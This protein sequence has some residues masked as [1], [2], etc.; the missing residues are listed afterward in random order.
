M[1]FLD[2]GGI[3]LERRGGTEKFSICSSASVT[4]KRSAS[5]DLRR[6]V[7]AHIRSQ[8]EAKVS[9]KQLP[10][11]NSLRE[12]KLL[13]SLCLNFLPAQLCHIMFPGFILQ[14]PSDFLSV[15]FESNPQM[16]NIL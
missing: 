6:V 8:G 9:R 13:I 2:G 3:T 5:N 11:S 15:M 12:A 14:G 10:A 4:Q 7:P 16:L 1:Y